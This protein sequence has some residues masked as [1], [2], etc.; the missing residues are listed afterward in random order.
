MAKYAQ[1][2]NYQ[3]SHNLDVFT[4]ASF[5]VTFDCLGTK[6]NEWMFRRLKEHMKQLPSEPTAIELLQMLLDFAETEVPS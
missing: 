1:Y 4:G 3:A 6:W 2:I 5:S